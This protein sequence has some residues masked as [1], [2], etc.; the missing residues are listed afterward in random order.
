[1]RE[2]G[3]QAADTERGLRA[4]IADDPYQR[5]PRMYAHLFVFTRPGVRRT[6]MCRDVIGADPNW[7][8]LLSLLTC[9]INDVIRAMYTTTH[10]APRGMLETL[11]MGP[12]PVTGGVILASWPS[13]AQN[14]ADEQ[15]HQELRIDEDGDLSF[16]HACAG[17]DSDP[18]NGVTRKVLSVYTI[19]GAVRE[20]TAAA[21]AISHSAHI[22]GTW[23]I[24]IALTGIRGYRHQESDWPDY[25]PPCI[26][27]E[28][29][30]VERFNLAAMERTP[31]DVAEK[32]PGRLMR[33]L[34]ANTDPDVKA[35]LTDPAPVK[36]TDGLDED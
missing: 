7:R 4:L 5:E 9:A 27:D 1:M 11:I 28:Y 26:N 6:E 2:R 21:A 12:R 14:P 34:R 18:V 15:R 36:A 10:R 33:G 22:P 32:L 31:G 29:L 30:R 19:I 35:L 8:P 25:G 3:Q 24:G 20:F 17:W 23:H 16:F 13:G